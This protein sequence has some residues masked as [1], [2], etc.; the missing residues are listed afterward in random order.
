MI[1]VFFVAKKISYGLTTFVLC[2]SLNIFEFIKKQFVI[3]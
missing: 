3:I 2:R 1:V